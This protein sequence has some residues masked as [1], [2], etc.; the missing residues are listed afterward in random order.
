M[1]KSRRRLEAKALKPD[2]EGTSGSATLC[3][4]ESSTGSSRGRKT[5]ASA[6][7]YTT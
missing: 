2:K 4:A 6:G 3:D 1:R 5:S 7:L